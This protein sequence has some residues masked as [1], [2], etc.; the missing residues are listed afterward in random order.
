MKNPEVSFVIRTKNEGKFIGKVLGLLQK[1][2]FKDFEII[3]VD[4]GSTDKTLE[5]VNKYSAKVLKIDP[6]DF[7]YSYAL[8][9]GIKNAS[10]KYI[11]IISGHSIPIT[12]SWLEDGVRIMKEDNVAGL[13]GYWTDFILGYFSRP[14]GRLA[15]LLPYFKKR[16]DFDPWLTN[17]NS[18]INKK[19][20]QEYNFDEKLEGSEDYDWACEMISRGYN[21]AK[22]KSFSVFHSHFMVGRPGYFASLPIWKKQVAEINKRKGREFKIGT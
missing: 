14:L 5:I 3:I 18:L 13:S 22:I 19:Y 17:T 20:W 21:I 2:T 16:K 4:S 11:C 7:N 10:G 9:F 1:Q 6:K 8:N 15:F 12:D